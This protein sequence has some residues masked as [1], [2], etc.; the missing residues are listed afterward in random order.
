V[1]NVHDWQDTTIP[2]S[3]FITKSRSIATLAEEGGML[4]YL[5]TF[6]DQVQMVYRT[7]EVLWQ[8]CTV[9]QTL[10]GMASKSGCCPSILVKWR[11]SRFLSI[12]TTDC[13]YRF[14][15]YMPMTDGYITVSRRNFDVLSWCRRYFHSLP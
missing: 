12:S 11:S 15:S 8:R 2:L 6:A 7:G 5:P 9:S 14:I 1:R 13:T 10:G 3:D 4:S